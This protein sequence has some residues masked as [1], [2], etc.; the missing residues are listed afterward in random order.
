V[1]YN[2]VSNKKKLKKFKNRRA[3]QV[4]S[5]GIKKTHYHY[6]Y[7]KVGG[8][9]EL[10]IHKLILRKFRRRSKRRRFKIIFFFLPNYS[11]SKKSTNSRM[12]KGKGKFRRL[13]SLLKTKQPLVAFRG[14]A[15]ARILFF[16]KRIWLS[17]NVRLI[18]AKAPGRTQH[19][20]LCFF[21]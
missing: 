21:I 20:N 15:F 12:G 11:F 5:S 3:P 17:N 2:T 1:F 8:L 18:A 6:I 10:R 4:W 19:E 7:T 9:L 14:I 13:L 16:I